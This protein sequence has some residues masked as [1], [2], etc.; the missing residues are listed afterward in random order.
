MNIKT[1]S[2]EPV[3]RLWNTRYGS[4]IILPL[5]SPAARSLQLYGE[6][7]EQ[8]I[9]LLSGIV[10]ESQ[11]ILEFGGDYGAHALWLAQAVGPQG[12]VHIAEPNRI[13][14]Q[15]TCANAALNG[16]ANVY[17]HARWLGRSK[18]EANLASL[19]GKTVGDEMVTITSVDELDLEALHLIK[20]NVAGSL[21]D[22]LAGASETIRK[23]RPTVYARLAGIDRAEAEVQALKDL[24]YRCWSHVPYLYNTDNYAES[25][26]NIFPGCVMQNVIASPVEGRFELETRREL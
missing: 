9:D 21:I 16:L 6:W 7:A 12:Q 24:G 25:S 5:D 10:Q 18:G 26:T 20:V 14:F 17:A 1:L 4:S 2:S 13:A 19:A 15:Q 22:L 11:T 23:Y 8:E 3:A